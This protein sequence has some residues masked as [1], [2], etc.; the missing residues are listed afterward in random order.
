MINNTVYV[1]E[2]ISDDE[3]R[4][5]LFNGQLFIY[6]NSPA[7][8]AL[9]DH[10]RAMTVEAFGGRDPEVAQDDM[11]VEDYA[12]LLADLKPTFIHHPRSKELIRDILAEFGA[13]LDKTY[14]DVPRMRTSTSGGYL[15]TG[16]AY[17]FHPHRDTW[18]SAPMSQVNWWLPF[19]EISADNCVAFHPKYWETPVKNGS[20]IYNYAEWT[21]TSRV[22]A[23]KHIGTD[24]RVQPKPEEPVELDPQIRPVMPVGGVLIFSGAQLHTSVPNTSGK[25]R[26]SLDFRTV[27]IDDVEADG[28]APNVDSYCTGTTLGD[29]LR[30]TDY[31]HL[32][33]ELIARYDT[34]PR[35][36]A[37]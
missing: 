32:P 22:E 29:Y 15:T 16:I 5:R 20:A 14:F 6:A 36:A 31:E 19:Y 23:A 10:A 13:D 17:A 37:G 3:R 2:A 35:A 9:A 24:T 21:Q 34:P 30:A 7:I 26:F 33:A 12:A 11:A 18:Y 27:H 1:N 8:K 4:R 25:T 28:G